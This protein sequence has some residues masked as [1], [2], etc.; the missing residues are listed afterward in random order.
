MD[1]HGGRVSCALPPH[2]QIKTSGSETYM[3]ELQ[4]QTLRRDHGNEACEPGLEETSLEVV[5]KA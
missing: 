3:L 1:G 5:R 2:T 4:L